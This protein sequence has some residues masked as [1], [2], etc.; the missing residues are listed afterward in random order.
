MHFDRVN[1]EP[2]F[3]ALRPFVF[4]GAD[5]ALI[6]SRDEPFKLVAVEFG[7]KDASVLV[8]SKT[9]EL[10]L[11]SENL[12]FF[13]LIPPSNAS[14]SSIVINRRLAGSNLFP[15]ADWDGSGA[16]PVGMDSDRALEQ[17]GGPQESDWDSRSVRSTASRSETYSRS[18]FKRIFL[19]DRPN[20]QIAKEQRHVN[21]PFWD[22]TSTNATSAFGGCSRVSSAESLASI[23]D[24]RTTSLLNKA[25]ASFTYDNGDAAAAFAPKLQ[26]LTAKNSKGELLF[27]KRRILLRQARSLMGSLNGGNNYFDPMDWSESLPNGS[28][29]RGMPRLR[30]AMRREIGGWPFHIVIM[31]IGRR[32]GKATPTSISHPALRSSR[33]IVWCTLFR[34]KPLVYVLSIP[35]IFYAFAFFVVAILSI[36]PVFLSTE[37][38]RTS[39]ATWSYPL[40]FDAA[41]LYFGLN[42]D[43]EP[44][45]ATEVS[46]T[47]CLY[48]LGVTAAGYCQY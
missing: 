1:S 33:P 28:N 47:A 19:P 18:P 22:G 45:A 23:V 41:S 10:A 6:P 13:T 48:R 12:L 17:E 14:R 36:H 34:T 3:T 24:E 2:E 11:K 38:A 16:R 37:K 5:F 4:S 29:E 40:A 25:I 30:F 26:L 42:V 39:A 8:F 7:C 20:K 31:A 43:E 15:K 44:S 32:V 35:R 46:S 21:D 27:E 9:I